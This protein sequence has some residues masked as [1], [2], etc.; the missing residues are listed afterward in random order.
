[1]LRSGGPH[2]SGMA[3]KAV[4]L[5]TEALRLKWI[6]AFGAI[7]FHGTIVPAWAGGDEL[8]NETSVDASSET[9]I[10]GNDALGLWG[11]LI[12]TNVSPQPRK[13]TS[14]AQDRA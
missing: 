14:S 9:I 6:A 2:V 1:M 8:I 4:S 12:S 10:G 11:T 13:A 3:G 5:L 7:C